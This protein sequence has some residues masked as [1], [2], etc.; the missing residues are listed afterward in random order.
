MWLGSVA[1]A[2]AL[3]ASCF[4]L[5]NNTHLGTNKGWEKE[6]SVAVLPF[7][8]YSEQNKEDFLSTG[9]A[10]DILNQLAQIDELKVIAQSSSMKYKGTDKDLMTIAKELDVTSLLDGSV[11][12][13]DNHL[14]ITVR[15]IKASDESIIWSKSFDGEFEDI[16]NVQRN[17]ALEVSQNMKIRLS[18][19]MKERFEDRV[20][21]DPEAYVNCQKGEELLKRSSG[22]YEDMAK[23]R[24][25]FEM[26]LQEDP[27][28]T[29]A[30]VGLADAWIE[31]I[32]W[33]RVADEDALPQAR[34]AAEKA[35]ALDPENGYGYGA[36]GA[37]N[38][39]EG[40]LISAEKNLRRSIEW[41][42]NYSFAY[43]RL[44][45]LAL[46]KGDENECFELY[47]KVL[48]LDPLST[49]YKGSMGSVYYFSGKFQQ[50]IDRMKE[51][52]RLDPMDN[53]IL[54][55]L[56][57]CYAGNKEYDKAIETLDKRTLGKNTNWIY[58]HCYAKL[59]RMEEAKKIL[60]HHLENK[61]TKHVPDFMMAIQYISIGD[62]ET[63]LDYLEKSIE[64][65]GENWFILGFKKDPM[66]DP[67]REYP[68]FK[69]IM[70]RLNELYKHN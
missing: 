58:T 41:N 54:W 59:G 25:Y 42:P 21:V 17:I 36:L 70:N 26:S 31:T 32:F 56:A 64:T 19:R 66:L 52:L 53:F 6:K 10:E 47:D 14:R 43:E 44:G 20:N 55:S 45:W 69:K 13:H 61:K 15:L 4:L 46:F 57:Y 38:L 37:V 12:N 50:G 40:D 9:I 67:V 33:H 1:L 30:W 27:T 48:K 18:P 62:N 35:M 23:A 7:K 8:N 16:L 29:Q 3:M 22:S 11:Q 63:G 65:K 60:A 2:C 68:R 28:F 39:L 49:R 34:E 5:N 24:Q 51:F